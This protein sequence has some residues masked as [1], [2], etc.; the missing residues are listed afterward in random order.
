MEL[1]SAWQLLQN[2][3]MCMSDFLGSGLELPLAADANAI[4]EGSTDGSTRKKIM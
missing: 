4:G 1:A 3:A 2:E